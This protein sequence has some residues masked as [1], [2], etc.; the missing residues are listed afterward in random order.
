[1]IEDRKFSDSLSRSVLGRIELVAL[2]IAACAL[3]GCSNRDSYPTVSLNGTVALDGEPIK[4]GTITF[5]PG[6]SEHGSGGSGPIEDGKYQ[7]KG[8]PK[9]TVGFTFSATEETGNMIEGPGGHKEPER[10]NP[11][12]SRYRTEGLVEEISESGQLDFELTNN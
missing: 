8:V 9:G 4:Q 2:S 11:V 7:L 1:M 5:V 6:E 10:I 12:P 3:V